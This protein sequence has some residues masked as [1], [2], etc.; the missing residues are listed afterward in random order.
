M[1]LKH[2]IL[3]Y[4]MVP[5]LLGLG[6]LGVNSVSANGM[7]GLGANLTPDQIAT[8][9]K[10]MFQS[11]ADLLGLSVDQVKDTWASGKSFAQLAKDQGI[12]EAQLQQ[13]IK[14]AR[15]AQ[16]KTQLSALVS[17]GVITQ[18]QADKRLATM[19]A[20]QTNAKGGKGMKG[21]RHGGLGMGMGWGL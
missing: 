19:Q 3:A 11:E 1:K 17:R 6:F 12:T 21:G 4:S 8:R 9:Q 16:I 7:F 13:K 20:A 14:D 18:S 15:A 10:T 5:A 2:K